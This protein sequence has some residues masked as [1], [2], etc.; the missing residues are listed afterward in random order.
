MMIGM[1]YP[2][3]KGKCYQQIINLMPPHNT[4]IETHL[5]GGSVLR[6]KKPAQKN[7]GIELDAKVIARW[8]EQYGNLCDLIEADSVEYL[9]Q[10]S[11]EGGELVYSDPPYL[12]DVRRRNKV[13]FCDYTRQDHMNLLAIFKYLRCMVFVSVYES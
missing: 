7:I 4:Y 3:G 5:G 6:H 12:P 1:R 9:Q 11:F 8:R 10:Y 13:Y 2:G